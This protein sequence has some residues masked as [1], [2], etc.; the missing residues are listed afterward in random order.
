MRP[1]GRN[2]GPTAVVVGESSKVPLIHGGEQSVD[3]RER[4]GGHEVA[5]RSH[6]RYRQIVE[7]FIEEQRYPIREWQPFGE[8]C[9]TH[10]LPQRGEER[11]N[12]AIY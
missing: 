10:V 11:A 7:S 9:K 3:G 8:W 5:M 2:E 6:V 4:V 12:A 1:S